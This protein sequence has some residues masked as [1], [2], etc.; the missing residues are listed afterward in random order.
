M[1]TNRYVKI[2]NETGWV[3]DTMTN[4]I[5]NTNVAQ[6][7]R[8]KDVKAQ[9]RANAIKAKNVEIDINNLKSDISEI[10]DMLRNMVGKNGT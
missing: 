1:K 7:E 4:A 9:R 3:R 5:I 10:K 8:A 2:E 6:M